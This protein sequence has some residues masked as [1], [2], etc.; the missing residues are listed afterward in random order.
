VKVYPDK[1][2]AH[3]KNSVSPI[4]IVS[5]DEPL[6]IQETCDLLRTHL[7]SAGFTERELFHA[8]AGFDWQQVLFSA[9]SMSLFAEQ[10]LIEIRMSSASPGEDGKKALLSYVKNVSEG[11]VL[12]LVMPRLDQNVQRA[13]WF[14]TIDASAVF[15]QIWPIEIKNLP[16]WIGDRFR[17]A[18]LTASKEAVGVMADR[19][20]GNLLAAVQEIERLS[21]VSKDGKIDTK[22]ILQGVADSSRYD[23][24]GLIDASVGGDAARTIKIIQGLQLEGEAILYIVAMLAR[25]LRGLSLMANEMSSGSLDGALKKGRVWQNRKSIV[26]SCLRN[27]SLPQFQVMLSRVSDIDS[28][29]KGIKLGNPWEELT[30]VMLELAGVRLPSNQISSNRISSN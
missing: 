30:S 16:R 6:L 3:L 22:D 4:Y 14:K 13:K 5:G 24:F 1:L 10:K 12:L 9:N 15:V 23:V 19:I 20:E 17:K 21:L 18:G 27:H 7:K 28:M 8:E 2:Q 29:V 26:S 11:T 25:E